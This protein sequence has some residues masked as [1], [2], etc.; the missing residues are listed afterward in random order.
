GPVEG[1][2]AA[3]GAQASASSSP[4]SR[5]RRL[6]RIREGAQIAGVCAGVGAYFDIDPNI[7]R[8]LFIIATII[9]SG[10]MLLI[11]IAMMFLIP[12][13]N[14]SEEWAAAHGVPFNAQEVIDRAKREYQHFADNGP[15]WTWSKWQRRQWKRE[16]RARWRSYRWGG[17]HPAYA[18][19]TP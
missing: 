14:T 11:Y 7:I 3:E 9:T 2:G 4:G 10:G 5:P 8:L 13:A 17:W 19:A 12:S 6:Y 18:A 1:E 15:P 16:M